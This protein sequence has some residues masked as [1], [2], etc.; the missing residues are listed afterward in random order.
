MRRCQN[1]FMEEL[2]AIEEYWSSQAA[3]YDREPDHGLGTPQLQAAWKGLLGRLVPGGGQRVLDVGCGT[4][5]LSILLAEAD[6]TVVGID[7]SPDM[8][9]QA[10][11]KAERSGASIDFRVGDA[12]DVAESPATFDVVLCRHLVWTLLEPVPT[13]QRWAR[14][15]NR[16]GRL[17]LIEG[18]WGTPDPDSSVQSWRDGGVSAVDLVTAVERLFDRVSHFPLSGE[19][20]LWGKRVDDERYA[21]V[22]ERPRPR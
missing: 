6:N 10:R 22:A 20:A 21:L 18:R 9:A 1:G 14:L 7:L 19:D 3:D 15:L 12:S 17:V 13:L 11:A 16:N 4:G 5:S 8:I 2:E